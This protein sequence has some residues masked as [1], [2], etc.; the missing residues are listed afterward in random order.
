MDDA[1]I[2]YLEQT[3]LEKLNPENILDAD[4]IKKITDLTAKQQVLAN[5]IRREKEKTI[6]KQDVEAK[7]A[8]LVLERQQAEAEEKQSR[9]I[10]EVQSR[11]R[12]EAEIVAQ[13]QKLRSEQARIATE[14]EVQIADQNRLRQVLVAEKSKERTAAVESERVEKD[15]ALEATERERIVTLAEIEKEKAVEQQKKDIQDVIRDRVIVERA[16]VEEEEK[17]KDT[18]EFA[19]AERQKQVAVTEAEMKA[20]QDLVKTVKAA[21]ATKQA[22]ALK[23]DE[24]IITADAN[25]GAAGTT[26]GRQKNVGRGRH[27]GGSCHGT[28]RSPSH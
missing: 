15:R 8:I 24:T 3:P 6:K 28:C 5:D 21:E 25:R 23:A 19:A 7:E 18:R 26:D 22:A 17:I 12:A 20:E 13:Q 2:D 11:E 16:V 1:A 4:G 27:R 10:A 14:E 9:E